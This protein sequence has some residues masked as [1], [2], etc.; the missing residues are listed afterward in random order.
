VIA[1]WLIASM[2][3][4]LIPPDELTLHPMSEKAVVEQPGW[5]RQYVPDHRVDVELMSYE[6]PTRTAGIDGALRPIACG[7]TLTIED[8]RTIAAVD[9]GRGAKPCQLGDVTASVVEALGR[10]RFAVTQEPKKK[11]GT[12]WLDAEVDFADGATTATVDIPQAFLSSKLPS[13]PFDGLRIVRP[14]Y[15]RVRVAPRFRD[16]NT[17][18]GCAIHFWI[19]ATGVPTDVGVQQ[20]DDSVRE[21]VLDAAWKW[22]FHPKLVNGEPMDAEFDLMIYYGGVRYR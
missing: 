12:Y 15:P 2:A 13:T 1:S 18:G 20:C 9:Q 8:D 4:S 16:L 11:R 10:W 7:F 22:R 3:D 6:L 14:A 17:K 5:P 21:E 19:D